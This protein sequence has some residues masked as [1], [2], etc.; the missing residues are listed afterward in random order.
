M[1]ADGILGALAALPEGD[2]ALLIGGASDADATVLDAD[3]DVWVREGQAPPEGAWRQ[4]VMLAGRGFGKT[5]A[6]AE[7]VTAFARAHP[8]AAIALVGATVDEARAVMI[9]GPSGLLSVARADERQDMLWRPSL[10]RLTFASGAEARLYS[11][12][13][14]ESLRGPEHHLAWCDELAKWRRAEAAWDNLR[15]GLRLGE[16]PRGL[17]TTTPR[18]VPLLK[19]LLADPLTRTGGGP[20]RANPHVAEDF[21]DAVEAA[22]GGTRFGRQELDGVLLDDLEGALWS[23]DLIEGSRGEM[24]RAETLT[25]IVVGVDPPA[26]AEGTCG[27]VVCGRDEAGIAYVLADCS[28]TGLGPDGWARKVAGAAE[29]WRAH[30]V[31]AEANNGGR[32]VESVLRGAEA[33]LPVTLVH[34]ADGKAARAEPVMVAFENGKA[35]LA[36]RFPALEDEMCGLIYG[37][38]YRGPGASPD[39]ADAMVWAMSELLAKPRAEPRVLRL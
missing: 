36:G 18:P 17:I 1:E 22:H 33:G 23:R 3:W 11:A 20:S 7:Y 38:D 28:A 27:I 16:R 30:R 29:S 13:N 39:R 37:G 5:R 31:I 32:M 8:D 12:A 26:S 35:K 15:L 10:K 19:R 2:L 25:R 9:E 6:G 4:W 21:L 34:A 24:P 14:P